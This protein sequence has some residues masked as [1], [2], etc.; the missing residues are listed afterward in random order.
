M[1]LSR[2]SS[3][4]LINNYTLLDNMFISEY[5]VNADEN[6]IKVYL[7]GLMQCSNISGRDN[8]LEGMSLALGIVTSEIIDAINYWE[9]VGAI[10]IISSDP[11]SFEYIPLKTELRS[12]VKKYDPE[13]YRDFIAQL[14]SMILHRTMSQN[15]LLKY[16]DVMDEYKITPEAMLMI[17]SYCINLKGSQ[18]HSNYI[19]TVAKA[20]A[21]EGVKNIDQVEDKLRELE[22]NTDSMR[23]VFYALGLKSSPDFDDKQF[24]IKWT[25][26]WGYDLESILF[27]AKLCKKR[28]GMKKLD[29]MLDNFY[30]L[31]LYNIQDLEEHNKRIE[32]TTNLAIKI[33]KSIGDYY[34]N[35]E[36]VVEQYIVPWL[37]KGYDAKGLLTIANYCFHKNIRKMSDMNNLV[38]EFYSNG[39]ISNEAIDEH[40]TQLIMVEKRIKGILKKLGSSRNVSLQDKDFYRVWT[41]NWGFS[42]DIIDYAVELCIGKSNSIAYINRLL[43][44]W[45]NSGL[46][47]LVECKRDSSN[48]SQVAS[49]TFGM[50]RN[51]TESELEQIYGNLED[52]SRFDF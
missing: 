2:L 24:Y 31:G 13:K 21:N 27:V 18:I 20:W 34:N 19:L 41:E 48:I 52:E 32:Y 9:S 14:E 46:K 39:I 38:L 10:R 30:K 33:V 36:P 7:Y 23:Q 45:H 12:K 25:S 22:A 11:F 43:S 28:G 4:T 26:S 6:A 47:T 15:E 50:Q 3:E 35:I 17:A 5:M 42:D 51:Y 16:I 8:T 1:A 29:S 49:S 44:N 40:F 37:E